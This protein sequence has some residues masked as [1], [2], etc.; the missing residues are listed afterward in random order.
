MINWLDKIG[1]ASLT[2]QGGDKWW[3]LGCTHDLGVTDQA[4]GSGKTNWPH[5]KQAKPIGPKQTRVNQS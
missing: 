5:A 4:H 2:F 3:I 1:Q